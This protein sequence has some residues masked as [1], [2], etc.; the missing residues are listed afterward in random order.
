MECFISRKTDDEDHH[1]STA[2]MLAV[3]MSF[4]ECST[5]CPQASMRSCGVARDGRT[6]DTRYR[7]PL[8]PRLA[9]VVQFADGER[10]ID[11]GQ[12][13]DGTTQESDFVSC[14]PAK[15][16]GDN[17]EMGWVWVLNPHPPTTRPD[18]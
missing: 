7:A 4:T 6:V 10:A 16:L 18:P 13:S 3:I 1:E 12:V 5:T 14:F 8:G 17:G 15:P 9:A 2:L 11:M